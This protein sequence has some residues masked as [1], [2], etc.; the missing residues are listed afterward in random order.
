ML[1]DF[2]NPLVFMVAF[3]IGLFF[4]YITMPYPEIVIKYPTP[5]NAGKITYVDDAN[6]CYKYAIE[7]VNCPSDK[8]KIKYFEPT[9]V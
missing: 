9:Q 5:Y 1:L 2:I 7:Q 6:V 4:T 8:S 3:C